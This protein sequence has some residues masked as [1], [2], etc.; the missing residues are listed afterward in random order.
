MNILGGNRVEKLDVVFDEAY[1]KAVAFL[2]NT[3]IAK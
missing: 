2:Y 1:R 3:R